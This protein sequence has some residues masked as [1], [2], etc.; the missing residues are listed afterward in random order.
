MT[1]SE[2]DPPADTVEL[3]RAISREIDDAWDRYAQARLTLEEPPD[4][5]ANPLTRLLN[6]D[7]TADTLDRAIAQSETARLRT[8][9]ARQA[10][11]E[12]A[13][14][15]ARLIT[16]ANREME[17]LRARLT[18][19]V[20]DHIEAERRRATGSIAD[21]LDRLRRDTE[22]DAA[23]LVSEARAEAQR[24]LDQVRTEA[25]RLEA[26]VSAH[27]D[28]SEA[29]RATAQRMLDE[30]AE[31]ERVREATLADLAAMRDQ[32]GSELAGVRQEIEDERR[33]A[34]ADRA[35]ALEARRQA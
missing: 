26:E 24:I 22:Q 32:T 10:W 8:E 19:E 21:D 23:R 28:E 16:Q 27:R 2:A 29:L 12:A 34:A 13:V 30:A 33:D 11:D 3:L 25:A 14:E 35:A 1:G 17:S 4:P 20:H 5:N 18:A 31:A 9:A 15:R 7:R 6:R